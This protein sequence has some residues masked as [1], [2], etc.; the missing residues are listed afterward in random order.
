MKKLLALVLVSLINVSCT[1]VLSKNFIEYEDDIFELQNKNKKVISYQIK[2]RKEKLAKLQKEIN[3]I[4]NYNYKVAKRTEFE[5]IINRDNSSINRYMEENNKI[6][7]NY[8]LQYSK[9]KGE[10]RVLSRISQKKDN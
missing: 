7:N 9:I 1:S 6:I 3:E 10:I 4:E 8:K 2:M 5:L